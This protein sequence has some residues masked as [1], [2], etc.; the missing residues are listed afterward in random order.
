VIPDGLDKVALSLLSGFLTKGP[1]GPPASMSINIPVD[2]PKAAQLVRLAR[3]LAYRQQLPGGVM[4]EK[5]MRPGA[6]EEFLDALRAFGVDVDEI[7]E[8]IRPL[9]PPL[10]SGEQML[11]VAKTIGSILPGFR[12]D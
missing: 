6:T 2:H 12:K 5:L 9:P 3:A 7:K 11:G 1:T 10:P 8:T 4:V